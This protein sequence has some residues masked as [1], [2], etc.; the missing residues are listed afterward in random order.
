[1]TKINVPSVVLICF[2]SSY[3]AAL[4]YIS[5]K[6]SVV[7]WVIWAEQTKIFLWLLAYEWLLISWAKALAI[8]A[9]ALDEYKQ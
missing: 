6:I 2:I 5:K 1:M 9:S 3:Y 4:L 7:F 8:Y